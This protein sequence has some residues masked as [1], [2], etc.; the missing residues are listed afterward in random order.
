[1]TKLSR[2]RVIIRFHEGLDSRRHADAIGEQ[3]DE[4]HTLPV[5]TLID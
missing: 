5:L 1:M 3:G 2:P 4:L